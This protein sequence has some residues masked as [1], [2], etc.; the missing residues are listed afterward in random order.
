MTAS[1]LLADEEA[2]LD[3]GRAIA[4]SLRGGERLALVGELGAGKTTLVKGLA[5]AALGVDPDRVV[6]PTFVL[7][8]I[9]TAAAGSAG[10]RGRVG[11]LHHVDAHRLRSGIEFEALGVDEELHSADVLVVEWADRLPDFLVSADLV[12]R[13]AH[14]AGGGRLVDLSGRLAA[15]AA[16]AIGIGSQDPGHDA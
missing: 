2:T 1:R 8:R 10:A 5:C 13:L 15:T 4:L 12:V 11:R 3:L 6:S 14:R 9:Y 16:R 7:H